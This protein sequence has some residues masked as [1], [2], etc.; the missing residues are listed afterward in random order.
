MILFQIFKMFL[1]PSYIIN[2]GS[3]FKLW[4]TNQMK[5]KEDLYNISSCGPFIRVRNCN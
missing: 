5:Y 2:N 1:L 4:I 3:V